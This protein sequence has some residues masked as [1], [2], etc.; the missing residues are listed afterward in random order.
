MQM[1]RDKE[2]YS[3]MAMQKIQFSAGPINEAL[4]ARTAV[5]ASASL[6]AQRDLQRYY[7]LMK[8]SLPKFTP[9]QARLLVNALSLAGVPAISVPAGYVD[10]LPV[11]LQLTAPAFEEARMLG[12]AHA[13]ERATGHARKREPAICAA[14]AGW[15]V[16]ITVRPPASRATFKRVS[17]VGKCPGPALVKKTSSGPTGGVTISPTT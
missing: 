6:V 8:R 5:N 12:V 9:A 10:D 7:L 13:F 3:V 17:M 14:R 15:A 11:G 2:G 4:A 1:K 16:T